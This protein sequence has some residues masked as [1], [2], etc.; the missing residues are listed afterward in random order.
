[1]QLQCD[2]DLGLIKV[3]TD[4]HQH[5]AVIDMSV[6]GKNHLLTIILISITQTHLFEYIENFTTK[7][8]KRKIFR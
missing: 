1:M 5:A 8:K 6:G 3:Y 4:C 7:K 2:S